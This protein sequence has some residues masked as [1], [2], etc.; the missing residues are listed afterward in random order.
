MLYLLRYGELALKSEPV[1]KRW[2]E[3][4]IRQLKALPGVEEVR[5]ERGRI[6]VEGEV[7]EEK[8]KKVFGIV[9]F[10]PCEK[11]GL[12][13]L[14]ER[15][16]EFCR[17]EGFGEGGTFA[18]RVKRTGDHPFTS[19]QK[20]AELGSLLQRTFGLKVDLE[21]PMR[22][23]FVEI[24][25]EECF[26]F[27][28]VIRGAGG[29]PLGVEGK[30]VSLF[31]GGIDSPVASWMAMKRGCEVLP[32]YFDSHPFIPREAREKAERVV[33]ILSEYQPGL[34]LEVREHGEFLQRVR[35]FL[36]RRGEE[37]YLCLLCK[38]R[39]YRVGEEVARERG[40]LALVTGESLGQVASQT[41]GNLRVL[42]E[43]CSLPVLRPLIGFDKVEIEELARKIGTWEESSREVGKCGAVPRHPVT[44]ASLEKVKRLEE[45][46][47]KE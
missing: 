38:R 43:A 3:S 6:W 44:M 11:C 29:I 9:S 42:E 15:V 5:R 40:A 7:P 12:G 16:V 17:R 33:R 2:E 4:L 20:A 13:E 26:L 30:V 8:L 1:R 41:L 24:R 46:L 23:L 39:M 10:S 37:G 35:E 36:W 18:V 25:G 14:E 31:S 19:P 47:E 27:T 32:L 22:E 45:E 34:E 21:H 28:K